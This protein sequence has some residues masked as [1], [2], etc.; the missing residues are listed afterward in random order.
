M[1]G[2][3]ICGSGQGVVV[4]ATLFSCL[5]SLFA[6]RFFNVFRCVLF[7][8]VAFFG[9]SATLSSCLVLLCAFRFF[10]VFR[11]FVLF[12]FFGVFRCVLFFF[13][14]FGTKFPHHCLSR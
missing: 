1:S 9:F 4:P 12:V 7:F 8:F 5:G 11:C 2:M 3:K 14:G 6:F 13:C 10:N